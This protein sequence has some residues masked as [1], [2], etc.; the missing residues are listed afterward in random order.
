MMLVYVNVYILQAWGGIDSSILQ[1]CYWEAT[2]M[3]S[4][5]LY[6]TQ[7]PIVFTSMKAPALKSWL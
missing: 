3:Q 5:L 4:T 1:Y 2:D 7:V 6:D